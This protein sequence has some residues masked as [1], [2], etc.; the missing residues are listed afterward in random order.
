MS[1][2]NKVAI[3]G[4]GKSGK[5]AVSLAKSLNQDFY[6]VNK[7]PVDS[8]FYTEGLDKI[9]TTCACYSEDD[10]ATHF[11]KMDEIVISPGIPTTH[12]ALK[13]A[14]EKGVPIISEIEYAFRQTKNIPVIAITGTNGKTTTTTMIAEAL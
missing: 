6:A 1:K 11:A 9:I 3:F 7:G 2:I 8:W 13:K 10:F 12:P 5:A 14:V 4:M